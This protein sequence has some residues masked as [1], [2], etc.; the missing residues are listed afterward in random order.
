MIVV[1]EPILKG[2]STDYGK[3]T[4]AIGETGAAKKVQ[5]Q[6]V[7]VGGYGSNLCIAGV[8]DGRTTWTTTW[9]IQSHQLP[10]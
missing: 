2:D 7:V 1:V 5:L 9:G 6:E 3:Y 4:Y 10:L 8:G